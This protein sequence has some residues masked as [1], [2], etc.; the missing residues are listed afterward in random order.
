MKLP[1]Y[2]AMTTE[3]GWFSMT[4]ILSRN[5]HLNVIT[6]KRSTGKSTGA[7]L[8]V[9]MYYLKTGKGWVYSRRTK[10]ETDLTCASWFDNAV[11]ILRRY[12]VEISVEYRGGKYFANGELAGEAIPMSLQ[13]KRKGDNLS[14]YDWLIYDEFI[15]FDGRYLG[16]QNNPIFEYQSIM[17]LYQTMDRDLDRAHRNE[18][19]IIALGNSDSYYNP[20]YMAT[21]IDKYLTLETHFLAPKG[22]EWVVEQ[23]RGEDAPAAEDYLESV[24]YKLSDERTKAYAFENLAKEESRNAFVETIKEPMEP[25]CNLIFNG[26]NMGVHYSWK[27]G[28]YYIDNKLVCNKT[29]ALTSDDHKPAYWLVKSANSAPEVKMLKILYEQGRVRFA[30]AKIKWSI[31]NYLHYVV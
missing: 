2:E 12:N 28:I 13:Q 27:K 25:V 15:S 31:D 24:A 29:Y 19:K 6:G 22:E 1:S 16:G 26:L 20:V 17:S 30:T 3:K 5:R 7:A 14:A 23:L 9:L 21:G 18:V 11:D 8:Y 10:D 4:P